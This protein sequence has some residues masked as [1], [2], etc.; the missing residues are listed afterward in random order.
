[1]NVFNVWVYHMQGDTGEYWAAESENILIRTNCPDLQGER[2]EFLGRSREDALGQ[3]I[4]ALKARGYS[5]RVRVNP[6]QR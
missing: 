6:R 1:M 4:A 3:V 2:V 5:G